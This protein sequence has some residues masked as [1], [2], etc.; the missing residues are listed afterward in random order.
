M[1]IVKWIFVIIGLLVLG[2]ILKFTVFYDSLYEREL[3]SIKDDLSQIPGA[4]LIDI[5]GYQDLTLEEI[6]ARILV[7][8]KGEI[9]LRNLSSD[10]Y[11]YPDRVL[12]E[13][14]GGFS[15]KLIFCSDS[16]G[17]GNLLD[18]SKN[19]DVGKLIGIDF[20]SPKDVI[21]NYDEILKA[22]KSLKRAPEL[23]YY[24][25]ENHEKYLLVYNDVSTEVVPLYHSVNVE[26]LA[27][28]GR[29]LKW[30]GTNCN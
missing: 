25:H 8:G 24:E 16:L 22:I 9:V 20:N 27:D 13:E 23:N 6:S 1:K 10:V 2:I 19:S 30:K 5:W 28:F 29:T 18:I 14:I 26:N 12:I 17:F 21:Q 15:F 4:I 11:N 3:R 7:E